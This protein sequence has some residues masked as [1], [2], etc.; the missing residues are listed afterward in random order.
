[1]NAL[2][3]I[4]KKVTLGEVI[5]IGSI[6]VSSI[7]VLISW[8][9]D[10][11]I[12]VKENATRKRMEIARTLNT[13]NKVVQLHLS[14]YDRIEENIVEASRIRVIDRESIKARDYMW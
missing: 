9:S 13:L 14:F 11:L 2:F 7:S 6:L 3:T 10:Q 5:T 8:R 4:E 1:M 12:Q